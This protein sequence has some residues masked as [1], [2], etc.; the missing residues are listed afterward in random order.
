MNCDNLQTVAA[1]KNLRTPDIQ[2]YLNVPWDMPKLKKKLQ[3][4]RSFCFGGS[5]NS[6]P[7]VSPKKSNTQKPLD[8]KINL[9]KRCGSQGSS[10]MLNSSVEPMSMSGSYSE[11]FSNEP[12]PNNCDNSP[13][14]K[15]RLVMRPKRFPKQKG[16]D[17]YSKCGEGSDS[18]ISISSQEIKELLDVPWSMPKLKRNAWLR[19]KPPRDGLALPIPKKS[20]TTV[21]KPVEDDSVVI[22]NSAATSIAAINNSIENI[23]TH[24]ICDTTITTRRDDD[25]IDAKDNSSD[26]NIPVSII[27]TAVNPPDQSLPFSMPKLE[28]RLKARG[29]VLD[30]KIQ[31]SGPPG[32]DRV[33]GLG[34]KPDL[35][36]LSSPEQGC[37]LDTAHEESMFSNESFIS[38]K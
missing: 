17:L 19:T 24:S 36:V 20:S 10:P 22:N 29:V 26:Y 11:A 38:G 21:N 13:I 18:G 4:R 32:A 16:L 15:D 8:V 2:H 14:S 9:D 5:E 33:P 25:N 3:Y 31:L 23:T 12:L 34:L 30:H 27:N 37:Q 1:L 35:D 7:D 28:R 6:S